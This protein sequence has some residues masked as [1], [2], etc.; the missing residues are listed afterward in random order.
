MKLFQKKIEPRC[1]YCVHSRP[2]NEEQIA[3]EKKGIMSVASSCRRFEYDPLRRTPPR[4]VKPEFSDLKQ[5]D[6]VL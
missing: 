1:A 6:F 5:E 2:L 3:C 4:P